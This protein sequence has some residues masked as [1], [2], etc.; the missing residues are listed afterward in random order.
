MAIRPTHRNLTLLLM[1]M[2][3]VLLGFMFFTDLIGGPAILG[4]PVRPMRPFGMGIAALVT[5]GLMYL[6]WRGYH[7]A[8]ILFGLALAAAMGLIFQPEAFDTATP[9]AIWIPFILALVVTNLRWALVTGAV[10]IAAVLLAYPNAFNHPSHVFAS[11]VILVL[12]IA[13]R[14]EQRELLRDSM[15]AKRR[16]EESEGFLR[17]NELKYRM[18]SEQSPLAII[19]FAPDGRPL[20][21]NAAWERLWDASFEALQ[22]Y[23]LLEDRQLKNLGVL[24]QLQQAFDGQY[25]EIPAIRY[26]RSK[27]AIWIRIFAYPLHAPDGRV[28]E[29]IL[30]E[31]DVSERVRAEEQIRNLAYFDPLT[32]LPNRRLLT[33]RLG[34][35]LASS[36]RSREFGALMILDLDHFKALNDT[37]GHDVG[38]ELLREV[39]TRLSDSIRACDTVSRFG[40]DEFV[41]ILEEM[42][43]E[44]GLAVAH[45][46]RLAEK[47]LEVIRRPFTLA[48][49]Y[50]AYQTSTSIGI[51]LFVGQQQS[52]EMLL[53]QADVALYQA[54]GAGR[55]RISFFSPEMQA[56]IEERMALEAALRSGLERREFELFYQPQFDRQRGMIGAEALLRWRSAEQGMISPA[57][58]VPL[59]EESGLIVQIGQWVLDVA[60]AQLKTWSSDPQRQRLQI[61][62]N[63]SAK[64]F[65][66]TDF[67]D[68]VRLAVE[69]H[70]ILPSRLKL[71]LTESVVLDDV[72]GIIGKM[73]Q[74]NALGIAFALDDFGTGYSSLSYLKRLPLEQLKVDQSFVRD[75]D[76][77]PNDAAIV[78]AILAM[79]RSLGIQAI[80]EGVE[81]ESQQHFL[82]ENG[83]TTYQG[84]FFGKPMPIVELDALLE[85]GSFRVA[86]ST[87]TP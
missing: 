79:S 5:F 82:A 50:D 66:Q 33:D 70:G 39:A 77:D 76:T 27:G 72:E 71:E 11:L 16:A 63:V 85:S 17:D 19:S 81:T 40:G 3:G 80:A 10:T 2:I 47:I 34:Q 38:D 15:A 41:L 29:V 28:R 35:A 6:F 1:G 84:Y 69:R 9:Q 53:K 37:Q 62:V 23:R 61:S 43:Q 25:V 51:A 36:K 7:F 67:V 20:R 65:M 13:G 75:I 57:R 18:L 26:E 64:Q 48:G 42:G 46:E 24:P 83:C 22:H 73:Q 32:N 45:A 31:E 4:G 49:R 54:K 74:L 14:L 68:Q 30:I 55:N 56:A 8:V 21:V 87:D 60:C 52:P 44:E 58:F 86:E 78:Q 59:A 12:L